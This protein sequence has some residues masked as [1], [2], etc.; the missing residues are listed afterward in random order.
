MRYFLSGAAPP[1]TRILLVESGSRCVMERAV[2]GM[3]RGFPGVSFELC[4]CFP[5]L[6]AALTVPARVWR[7]NDEPSLG[8]KLRMVRAIAATRPPI[9]A[10]LFS[11]EPV[12][13]NWKMILLATLPSK[14]LL[15][16]ENGDFF[17][18]DRP[19]LPTLRQFLGARLGMNGEG[20]VRGLTR[21]LTFP[22]VFL[23]LLLVAAVTYFM[24]WTRLA[25]WKLTD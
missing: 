13:F 4:T 3:E 19:N 14:I 12:M 24:R 22:F 9:A 17:W 25:Y 20:M 21:V 11:G 10:L 15:I 23:F 8:G 6:P 18:L 5:G 2:A 7:V 16:N 1:P